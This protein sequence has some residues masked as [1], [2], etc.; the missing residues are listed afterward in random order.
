MVLAQYLKLLNNLKNTLKKPIEIDAN[1]L[2]IR[3]HSGIFNIEMEKY[4]GLDNNS[5]C[6][7][8]EIAFEKAKGLNVSDYIIY[9]ISLGK[10]IKKEQLMEEDMNMIY[11]LQRVLKEHMDGIAILINF[12]I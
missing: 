9:D 12:M 2:I 1:A 7:Y 5:I 10:L 4:D 3:C 6:E 8:A 11:I